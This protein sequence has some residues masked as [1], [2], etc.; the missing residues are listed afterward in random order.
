MY[1]VHRWATPRISLRNCVEMTRSFRGSLSLSLLSLSFAFF[2]SFSLSLSLSL[3]MYRRRINAHAR[4]CMYVYMCMY[5]YIYVYVYIGAARTHTHA[6][7]RTSPCVHT[8]TCAHMRTH[9]PVCTHINTRMYTSHDCA[10]TSRFFYFFSRANTGAMGRCTRDALQLQGQV[11]SPSDQGAVYTQ[12]Y[13]YR[14]SSPFSL[15]FSD[16][17]PRPHQRQHPQRR[18]VQDKASSLPPQ[19][20]CSAATEGAEHLEPEAS[21][22]GLEHL[23]QQKG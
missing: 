4:T 7:E 8:S 12:G 16:A 9:L 6:H 20:C 15:S 10:L 1:A 11:N 5:T 3:S 13:F 22:E 18:A 23:H 14:S 19:R 17:A 2:L 21:A